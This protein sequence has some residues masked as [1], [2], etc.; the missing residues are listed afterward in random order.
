MVLVK[1]WMH[2]SEEEQ[3]ARFERRSRIAHKRWKLTDEDGAT[4]RSAPQ[5]E[6][7][8]GDVRAHGHAVGAVGRHP[9]GQQEVRARGRDRGRRRGDG[10]RIAAAGLEVPQDD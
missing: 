4:A 9:G 8:R 10:A 1:L 7:P 3:L 6:A 2:V 5:Y